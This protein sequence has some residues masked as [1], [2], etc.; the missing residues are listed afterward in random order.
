MKTH[1]Q[2]INNI[3]GQLNGVKRMIDEEKECLPV[4]TQM[5][6]A[7]SALMTLMNRYLEENFMDCMEKCSSQSEKERVC[8]QFFSELIKNN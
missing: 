2:F 4:Y 1:Q 5:K 8:G 3:I 6:A 7:N